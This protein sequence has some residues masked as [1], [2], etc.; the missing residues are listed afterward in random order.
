MQRS[1]HVQTHP[2]DGG[3]GGDVESHQ[4][5][6]AEGAVGGRLGHM[7]HAEHFAVRLVNVYLLAGD[8]QPAFFVGCHA[9]RHSFDTGDQN[10]FI[11]G[12]AVAPDIVGAHI[13]LVRVSN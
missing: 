7:D 11:G 6:V 12:H 3:A 2:V 4:I 5:A 9:I 1:F 10:A 13:T 8:V